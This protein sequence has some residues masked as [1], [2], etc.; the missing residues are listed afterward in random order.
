MCRAER[1]GVCELLPVHRET[2][3]GDPGWG[4][5]LA[6]ATDPGCGDGFR[7]TTDTVAN[8]TTVCLVGDAELRRELL[9]RETAREALAT[10]QLQEPYANTVAV[11][12]VSLGAALA[13]CNDL[14]WYLSRFVDDAW[15]L[16]PSVDDQE[17]LSRKLAVAVRA[18]RRD[19]AET[20][21]L[22]KVYGLRGDQLLDPMYL[23]R[24][25]DQLPSYDLHDV[26]DTV[27][28]RVTEAEFEQT[29]R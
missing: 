1:N 9:S 26:T 3:V 18:D 12:T 10:Y 29:G 20:G 21:R 16:E 7:T 22:L 24:T 11:E 28:V 8:V 5:E 13:L 17:W 14:D 6:T 25:G 2:P 19:P 23:A 15:I 4:D 27:R